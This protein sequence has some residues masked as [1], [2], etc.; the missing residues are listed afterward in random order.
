MSA[1]APW[2]VNAGLV[3]A[4]VATASALSPAALPVA[5]VLA[6]ALTRRLAIRSRAAKVT[7]VGLDSDA[8]SLGFDMYVHSVCLDLSSKHRLT[9]VFSSTDIGYM[10]ADSVTSSVK[11]V[12][13]GPLPFTKLR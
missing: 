7:Q 12:L 10:S 3:A 6:G 1:A 4:G 8:V 2:V 13:P 9:S 5:L 11:S